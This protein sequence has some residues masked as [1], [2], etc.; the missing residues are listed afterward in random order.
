[1]VKHIYG[2][3]PRNGLT[4]GSC[5]QQWGSYSYII[6]KIFAIDALYSV[7]WH[8]DIMQQIC[9]SKDINFNIYIRIMTKV[10]L[11]ATVGE[12]S[13]TGGGGGGLNML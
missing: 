8:V 5:L 13:A 9:I 6:F 1:M 4:L 3:I 11:S 10:N 2:Q 7:I 12:M